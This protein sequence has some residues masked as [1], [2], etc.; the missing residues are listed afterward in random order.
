MWKPLE[1]E[2]SS[3]VGDKKDGLPVNANF[4]LL[5]VYRW[6]SA[7]IHIHIC[8]GKIDEPYFVFVLDL[9]EGKKKGQDKLIDLGLTYQRASS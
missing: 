6:W 7:K 3:N 5:C 9:R 2:V 4:D 1:H 8:K